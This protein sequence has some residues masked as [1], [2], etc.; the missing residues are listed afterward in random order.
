MDES[1]KAIIKGII[2]IDGAVKQWQ[3][4]FLHKHLVHVAL[5]VA[6]RFLE[7]RVPLLILQD[8]QNYNAQLK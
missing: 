1:V 3:A 8:S 4:A 5:A 6:S 7:G 2:V